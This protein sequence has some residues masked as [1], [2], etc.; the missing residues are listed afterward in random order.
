MGVLG[1]TTFFRQLGQ[2]RAAPCPRNPRKRQRRFRVGKVSPQSSRNTS[3][4]SLFAGRSHLRFLRGSGAQQE[5][6]LPRPHLFE[7]VEFEPRVDT[8][9]FGAGIDAPNL[10]RRALKELPTEQQKAFLLGIAIGLRRKEC[11]LLQWDSFDFAASTVTVRPTEYHSLK[12]EESASTLSLDV[13]FMSMFR[14]W[15]AQRRGPFVL[16]SEH[17]PRPDARYHYYRCDATFDALVDWLRVQGVTGNKPFHVL[18]KL[19]GSLIVEKAGVFAAS[20]ALRHTSIE[21]TNSYYLDRSVKTT[22]G[23]GSILTRAT[24]SELPKDQRLT[25]AA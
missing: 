2:R 10:L 14:G 4:R 15:Y 22:S 16:E 21:L 7:G 23:L 3:G 25:P 20:S 9:F 5:P 6:D 24:V 17:P 18:R 11:D 1:A 19:F 13:E 8:R 12:T